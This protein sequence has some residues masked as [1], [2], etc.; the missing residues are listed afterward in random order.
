[1][2]RISL[3]FE[4]AEE[5]QIISYTSDRGVTLQESFEE[6]TPAE[7]L[8]SIAM[9]LIEDYIVENEGEVELAGIAKEEMN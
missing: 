8:A 1:M 3:I 9:T 2:A 7:Q 6:L 4:D 5:G